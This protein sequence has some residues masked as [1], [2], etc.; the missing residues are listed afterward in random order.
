[1]T[2]GVVDRPNFLILQVHP[3]IDSLRTDLAQ[4][5]LTF[6]RQRVVGPECLPW[7]VDWRIRHA[8]ELSQPRRFSSVIWLVEV[9]RPDREMYM[10]IIRQSDCL[11]RRVPIPLLPLPVGIINGRQAQMLWRVSLSQRTVSEGPT[12]WTR[13]CCLVSMMSHLN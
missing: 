13:R 11:L 5:V 6:L 3:V 9:G 1:M 12:G 7:L 10:F 2:H 8:I 4:T